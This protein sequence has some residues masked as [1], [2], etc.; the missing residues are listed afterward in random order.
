MEVVFLVNLNIIY[1]LIVQFR[2][3]VVLTLLLMGKP[4]KKLVVF[5][6]RPVLT[7]LLNVQTV[8]LELIEIDICH[9]TALR[10]I[11]ITYIPL[12]I[13]KNVPNIAKIGNK[14]NKINTIIYILIK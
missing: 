2:N 1:H 5:N 11:M 3:R 6:V 9:A 4:L 8:P 10:G 7:N 14:I 12:K 13:A